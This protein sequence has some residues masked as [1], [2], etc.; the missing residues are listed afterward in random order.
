MAAVTLAILAAAFAPSLQDAPKRDASPPSL[1]DELIEKSK[2]FRSFTVDFS[3]SHGDDTKAGTIHCDCRAPDSMHL[4]MRDGDDVTST[5][6]IDTVAIVRLEVKGVKSHARVDSREILDE[7]API[8]AVVSR[9]FGAPSSPT[10]PEHAASAA[11]VQAVLEMMWS[12]DAE[13]REGEFSVLA[14]AM[15][16]S[17]SPF[18]W[19][20]TLRSKRAEPTVD[21][22]LL[23]FKTDDDRFDV[24]V[25]KSDGVLRDFVGRS[26]NGT[27][28]LK[29]ASAAIDAPVPPALLAPPPEPPEGADD[30]PKY[31][32]IYTTAFVEIMRSHAYET[33]A[34]ALGD[35]PFDAAACAR[36]ERVLRPFSERHIHDAVDPWSQSMRRDVDQLAGQ[37][38]RAESAGVGAGLIGETRTR[39]KALFDDSLAR[40]RSNCIARVALPASNS[41]PDR[42]SRILAIE[43]EVMA[44]RFD[45][46]V[47]DP[48]LAE[49]AKAT[50]ETRK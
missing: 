38:R 42:A 41:P 26:A 2:Q 3:I 5:W 20:T 24:A 21:G 22:D 28:H 16:N 29:L 33:I 1:L 8:D 37:L 7:L 45:A 36:I 50:G 14:F 10:A 34:T 17:P 48:L 39:S 30:T 27:I 35:V 44:E 40:A 13:M 47:R 23:R 11:Q 15:A 46:L 4:E 43:R 49:F 12:F 31:R 9:E 18:G 6:C 19:L 32:A 25:S